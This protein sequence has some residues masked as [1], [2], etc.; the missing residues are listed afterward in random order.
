MLWKDVSDL[1]VDNGLKGMENK[2]ERPVFRLLQPFKKEKS[3]AVEIKRH[4]EFRIHFGEGPYISGVCLS[5][6]MK[7]GILSWISFLVL[8]LTY[9]AKNKQD[10]NHSKSP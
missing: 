10:K 1:C 4:D 2:A 9:I 6:R 7:F 5:V 8:C 3:V